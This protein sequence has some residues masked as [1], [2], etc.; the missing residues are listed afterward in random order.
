MQEPHVIDLIPA[1]ALG[2]LEPAEVD[3]VERHL[4][5][6][7]TCEAEARLVG[8]IREE[9]LLEPV[10]LRPQGAP[11]AVRERLLAQVR[12]LQT[13]RA[14]Q[15]AQAGPGEPPAAAERP[16]HP[17]NPVA[18]WLRAVFGQR[19]DDDVTERELRDLMLDPD[20]IV[21]QV[22]GTA[23]APG[24][25]ARLVASPQRE[26]AVLLASGL[27]TPGAGHAYQVWLLRDGQ[28]TPNALFAVDRRGRG[29][30][31][32]QV[33]GALRAWDTVAVTPEPASGSL[34]PTGPIVLAGALQ[35][36]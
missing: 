5:D 3:T 34:S 4:E 30:S 7:L 13:A 14:E 19:A 35:P 15:P 11:P 29:A 26:S 28:P 20:C 18:R 21:I 2:A 23:D 10:A 36:A 22:A 31:V 16:T 25:S 12:A 27:R 9:L 17:S 8:R 1:Y 33:R 32:V 24:A 6:C